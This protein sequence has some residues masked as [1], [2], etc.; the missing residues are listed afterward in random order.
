MLIWVCKTD[1]KLHIH[2]YV[3]YFVIFFLLYVIWCGFFNAIMKMYINAKNQQ[4]Y[5][6]NP[7]K[8]SNLLNEIHWVIWLERHAIKRQTTWQ[9]QNVK[10]ESSLHVLYLLFIV[11][12]FMNLIFKKSSNNAGQTHRGPNCLLLHSRQISIMIYGGF[13]ITSFQVP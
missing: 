5:V 2:I 1:I 12:I 10:Q 9:A 6:Y 11:T 3:K 8:F 4:K 7:K 13:S